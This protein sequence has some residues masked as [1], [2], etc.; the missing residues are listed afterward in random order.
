MSAVGFVEVVMRDL[1]VDGDGHLIDTHETGTAGGLR[2]H[3]QL[4]AG[5]DGVPELVL[6]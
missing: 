4:V 3:A 1:L 2:E 5:A 6:R